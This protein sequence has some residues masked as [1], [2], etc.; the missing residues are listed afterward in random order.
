MT[1]H[2]PDLRFERHR[3]RTPRAVR[4]AL[5]GA[6]AMSVSY[7]TAAWSAPASGVTASPA[8]VR[9]ALRSHAM[10]TLDGRDF[11][12]AQLEGQVVVVNFWASWCAPCR[13]ELPRLDALH[14]EMSAQGASVVAVSIDQSADNARR[15]A[16]TGRL[17][18]PVAHDGPSGL[19]RTLDLRHVPATVVLDRDGRIAWS[20]GRSDDAEL[21]K[22]GAV[23]RRLAGAVPVAGA[24]PNGGGR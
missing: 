4:A 2:S 1:P 15:F 18:M 17:S 9:A 13:R 21:A 23:V 10:K 16:K 3:Q 20:T 12:F 11:S 22:L 5:L 6:M 19:A 7:A 24:E 8:A 14:R